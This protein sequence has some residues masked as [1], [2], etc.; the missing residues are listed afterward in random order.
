MKNLKSVLQRLQDVGLKVKLEKCQFFKPEVE[1]FG[2]IISKQRLSPSPNKVDAIVNAPAPCNVKE[3]QSYLGLLNFYRRFLPNNSSTLRPLHLLLMAGKKWSWGKEEKQ[4]FA[5]SK[6]LMTTAPI[7][8]HYDSKKDL[9]LT[10]D[11]S[12]YGVGAVLAH[13]GSDGVERPVAFASRRLL[14]AE[15]NYSQVDREAL[16]LVFGVSKFHQYLWGR[17]FTAVTDHKPLLGLLNSD[18]GVPCQASPRVTRWALTLSSYQFKLTYKPGRMVGHADGLSRLPLPTNERPD[19]TPA[20]VFMLDRAYPDALSATAI[21]RMTTRDPV[22]SQVVHAVLTGTPLPV[23]GDYVPFAARYNELSLHEGCLLWGS[24]V[25]VP[26]LMQAQV[27]QLLHA[28][29]PGIEKN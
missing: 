22:I 16:A 17:P 4:A 1:Y 13:I 21:A 7:L 14:P 19:S 8:V 10:C 26:K 6:K 2:H 24:R 23:G 9:L 29:H 28:G 3:L 5:E 15:Q 12:P 11:A 25:V 27:L 18:R 20:D